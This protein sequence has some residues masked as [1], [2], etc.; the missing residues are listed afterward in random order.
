MQMHKLDT[1]FYLDLATPTATPCCDSGC[2]LTA[3]PGETA[4]AAAAAALQFS[5]F[6]SKDL[7]EANCKVHLIHQLT[8]LLLL[9]P[10]SEY[11]SRQV[12]CRAEGFG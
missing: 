10:C 4:A 2:D 6:L 1:Q 7:D 11:V 8:L 5:C 9:L 3:R 12:R